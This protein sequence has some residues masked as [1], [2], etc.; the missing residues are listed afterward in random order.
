MV[1]TEID[2]TVVETEQP[3]STQLLAKWRPLLYVFEV[4]VKGI[5]MKF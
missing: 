1:D 4:F 2:A 5:E 3:S